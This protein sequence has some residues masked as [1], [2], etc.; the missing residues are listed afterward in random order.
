MDE[1]LEWRTG[2]SGREGIFVTDKIDTLHT[3]PFDD[4]F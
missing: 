4:E 1:L 2:G 3:P